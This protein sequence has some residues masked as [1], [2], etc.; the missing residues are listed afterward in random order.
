MNKKSKN[1]RSGNSRQHLLKISV[2]AFAML[3]AT[4]LWASD[5]NSLPRS[6]RAGDRVSKIVD[7][8]AVATDAYIYGYP[9]ILMEYTRRSTQ[10]PYNIFI[11][12]RRLIGA[13]DRNVVRPNNDSLYSI[14]YLDLAAEPIVLHVPDIPG[15]P[16]THDRYYIMQ[17]MDAWTNVFANP[18]TITTGNAAQDFVL[19]GP[20]WH[21]RL[22]KPM[23][24]FRAPTN[25]VW[26]LG[27]TQVYGEYDLSA[28]HA[29]QNAYRLTPLS[30]WPGATAIVSNPPQ[31]VGSGIT[32]PE[33]VAALTGM[34]FFQ[35][36]YSLMQANPAA[37]WDMPALKRFEAIGFVPGE[38]FN[39]PADVREAINAAPALA[40]ERIM[41]HWNT[42][43]GESAN[44]WN[45]LLKG[46]GTYGTDYLT[47]AAVAWSGLGANLPEDA[48]YPVAFSDINEDLLDGTQSYRIHFDADQ[49]PPVDG[50]WSLTLYDA[51]AYLVA[52][53]W[54]RYAIHDTDPPQFNSDGSLDIYLQATPPSDAGLF[55]N[56]LPT[57]AT[58][59]ILTIRMYAPHTSVLKGKWVPPPVV[60]APPAP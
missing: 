3:F 46:I 19:C 15:T 8:T 45:M 22:P 30:G 14:S 13:D 42:P 50:F 43:L 16:G 18:S 60:P 54:N 33:Q 51:E 26:I 35:E 47:R 11:H 31:S 2:L 34:Q 9:M 55:A 17:I 21:G 5:A 49:A 37:P 27:R 58:N 29:I 20:N 56:W 24:I 44:G 40:L 52:N 23:T 7:F 57:P 28:V 39:P 1:K 59:F 10:A 38:E 4:A 41:A 36:L 48:V 53:P 6:T 32:P 25:L 12:K